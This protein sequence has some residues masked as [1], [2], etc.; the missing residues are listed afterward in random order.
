M[1]RM[2]SFRVWLSFY[3]V[4]MLA[5][6]GGLQK[7]VLTSA[8]DLLFYSLVTGVFAFISCR[9]LSDFIYAKGMKNA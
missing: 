4:S 7:L 3:L 2:I 5:V 9:A 8:K 6:S 1:T